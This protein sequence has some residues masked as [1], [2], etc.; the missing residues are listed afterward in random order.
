MGGSGPAKKVRGEGGA[1]RSRKSREEVVTELTDKLGEMLE[2]LERVGDDIAPSGASPASTA[3]LVTK[4]TGS[5]GSSTP[6]F[7]TA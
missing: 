4:Q 5:P 2:A 6:S 7:T 3:T 1:A